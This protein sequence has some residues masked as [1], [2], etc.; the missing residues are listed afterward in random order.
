[1]D[2]CGR[3]ALLLL[4]HSLNYLGGGRGRAAKGGD[5]EGPSFLN[6]ET[7]LRSL[8]ECVREGEEEDEEDEEGEGEERREGEGRWRKM[9]EGRDGRGEGLFHYLGRCGAGAGRGVE[10]E[11]RG[12]GRA[13]EVREVLE[14]LGKEDFMWLCEEVLGRGEKEGEGEVVHPGL[15]GFLSGDVGYLEWVVGVCGENMVKGL[16]DGRGRGGVHYAAVG[17]G[18]G[19]VGWLVEF[20]FVLFISLF[21][22]LLKMFFIVVVIIFET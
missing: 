22:D 13:E 19:V 11:G 20:G 9:L 2:F 18:G 10:G 15:C 8:W 3:N 17:G 12:G 7:S 5:R 1:M 6:L 16:R 4:L 14:M 21:L